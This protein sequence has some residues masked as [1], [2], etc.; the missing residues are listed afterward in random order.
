MAYSE[1]D[2]EA[3]LA[4]LDKSTKNHLQNI[5]INDLIEASNFFIKV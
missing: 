4:A 2:M 1:E 3:S 5:D